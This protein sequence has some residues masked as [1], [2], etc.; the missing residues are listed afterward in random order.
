MIYSEKV[1]FVKAIKKYNPEISEQVLVVSEVLAT[2][3]ANTTDISEERK[4]TVFGVV[5]ERMKCV[6][7]KRMFIFPV[8]YTHIQFND[9]YWVVESL[10][11]IG[12]SATLIV[13]EVS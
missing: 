3:K 4:R 2:T 13:K 11:D 10:K 1:S 7:T 8:G 9:R 5:K 6:R 12:K